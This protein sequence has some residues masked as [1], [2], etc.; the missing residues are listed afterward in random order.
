[1]FNLEAISWQSI[2]FYLVLIAYKLTCWF[3]SEQYK[4][5]KKKN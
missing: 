2:F 5:A 1:M 4:K 3:T